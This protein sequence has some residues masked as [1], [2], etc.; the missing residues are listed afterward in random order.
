MLSFQSTGPVYSLVYLLYTC[1]TEWLIT[2]AWFSLIQC[3]TLFRYLEYAWLRIWL[4]ILRLSEPAGKLVDASSGRHWTTSTLGSLPRIIRTPNCVEMGDGKVSSSQIVGTAAAPC[5]CQGGTAPAT[6]LPTEPLNPATFKRVEPWIST[7]SLS[8]RWMRFPPSLMASDVS[9]GPE[10]HRRLAGALLVL[11]DTKFVG[12]CQMWDC[13]PSSEA[14]A[15]AE[16]NLL[17]LLERNTSERFSLLGWFRYQKTFTRWQALPGLPC[18]ACWRPTAVN[19]FSASLSPC[20]TGKVGGGWAELDQQIWGKGEGRA[21][22][23]SFTKR[24][25]IA[26]GPMLK[27][28]VWWREWE[29]WWT[30]Q[31][32]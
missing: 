2:E 26:T 30:W 3:L 17:L 22:V 8:G 21:D 9:P 18:D 29:R 24:W 20:S 23:N 25:R 6:C 16:R 13:F 32:K 15:G 1:T 19:D 4:V 10:W 28:T 14:C 5:F 11:R 27:C 7:V 12:G 31:E